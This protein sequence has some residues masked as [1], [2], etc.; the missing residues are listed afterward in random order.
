M[1]REIG[2]GHVNPATDTV[3]VTGDF[4]N[5]PDWDPRV[6][7]VRLTYNSADSVYSGLADSLASGST[8]KFKFVYLN[9]NIN[10]ESIADRSY[11]VPEADSTTFS[12]YWDNIDP[13]IQLVDGNIFFVVDMSVATELGVFNPTVDSVQIRG[14][15]NGWNASDPPRS[16]MIQDVDPNVWYLDIPMIQYQLNSTM[17]YKYFIQNGTGSV[18]YA[19]TG[20][21]VAISPTT[22]GNRDRPV[23]FQGL[24]DQSAGYAYFEGIHE[25]WVIPA[26]TSVQATFRVDMTTATGFTPATDTVLWIPR[27]PFFYSV[28]NLPWPGD[29]PRNYVLTDANSDMI[30]EG[31]F[32]FTGPDFNGYLYNYGY[33]DVSASNA[34]VQEGG[35]QEECRVRYIQ[36]TGPRQFVNPYTFPLDV[37]TASGQKPEEDPPTGIREFPGTIPSVYSLYQNF[38]NPFNPSTTIR[39]SIPEAGIVN[40]SIYNLLGEKVGEV[41]NRELVSGSYEFTYDASSLSSGIYFYTI[42]AGN[43]SATKKMML[44]K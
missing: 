39:F 43:Y 36:Q 15:F 5:W 44:I 20:W 35:N 3:V 22:S 11:F 38:P 17:F 19:N 41:L 33:V 16:L 40:L 31:T 6:S 27:Q 4:T 8:I 18:P 32:T 25:D 37:W 24:P 30:Y 2:L 26:G 42:K 28:H 7:G 12:A 29:Y 13:S 10:W 21:E 9:G 14:G 23:V 1:S 34:L